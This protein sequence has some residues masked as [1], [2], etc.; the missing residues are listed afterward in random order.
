M[1]NLI[2]AI[3]NRLQL[4]LV[5]RNPTH[6]EILTKEDRCSRCEEYSHLHLLSWP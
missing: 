6:D 4:N 2:V 5:V 1:E 3:R